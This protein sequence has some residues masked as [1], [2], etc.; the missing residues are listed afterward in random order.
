MKQF[1]V[2]T[3]TAGAIVT[4]VA[5]AGGMANPTERVELRPLAA[6]PVRATAV[7]GSDGRGT[8]AILDISKAPP[9]ARVRAVLNAGTCR[10]RSASLAAAGSARSDGAGRAHWTARIL[11]RNSAVD[12]NAVA[13]GGHI[14]V[15]VINGKAA[16]CGSIPGTS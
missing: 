10:K 7:V 2:V 1:A 13:D 5:L 14:L 6:S 3:A 9:H 16:A 4:Q 11:V 15:L 12:W 8:R